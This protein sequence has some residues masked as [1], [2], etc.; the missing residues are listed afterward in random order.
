MITGITGFVGSW[1]AEYILEHKPD[2]SVYGLKRWRS[3]MD[4]I[5]ELVRKY[6]DRL[7]LVDG[8]LRDRFSVD[9]A[10]N[11]VWP[12]IIFH[13]AAQSY[14]VDSYSAPVNTME[15][16]VMGTLNLL[17]GIRHRY[18]AKFPRVVLCS[19]SEVYGTA[20]VMP[21]PENCPFSPVSPYAVSKV[22]EDM[23]GLMYHRAY[24][25]PIIRTRAYTHTG[26]RQHQVFFIPSI[27]KQ[28]AETEITLDKTPIVSI[29]NPDSVRTICDVRDIVRAYWQL[30]HVGIPGDVYNIGG[31][32]RASVRQV[33]EMLIGMSFISK[34]RWTIIEDKKL[35]RPADVEMQCPSVKKLKSV[36]D[37]KPEILLHQTL[38]DTVNFWRRRKRTDD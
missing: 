14:V 31:V 5:S 3:P 1:L 20:S 13:L 23:L 21:T 24:Q 34:D 36:C 37:W 6:G 2:Y 11:S 28:V 26:P 16:N 12:D 29:G 38:E 33:A 10:L 35:L 25:M 27:A 30:A 19:S 17:E 4:N 8:D 9:Y 32:E 22:A 18:D 15:T 7:K